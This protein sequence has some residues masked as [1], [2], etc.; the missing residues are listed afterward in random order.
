MKHA[1]FV[2]SKRQLYFHITF[3]GHTIKVLFLGYAQ[4]VA[5]L[6]FYTERMLYFP[7]ILK[8]CCISLL[9]SKDVAFPCYT[10]GVVVH[11]NTGKTLW[12]PVIL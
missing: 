2:Y 6:F 9:H 10:N 8:G 4:R 7:V 11:L 12:F 3:P 5:Y 1:F